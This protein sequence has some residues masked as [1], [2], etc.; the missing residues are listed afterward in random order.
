[1]VS[2]EQLMTVSQVNMYI[3]NL[4]Q[5]DSLLRSLWV[6]G[7]ISNYKRHSS[8]HLYF[9]L[10]DATGTI[11][12][13]MFRSN[14]SRLRF[15]PEHGMEVIAMGYVS[16]FER[17]GAYQLYV[18]DM[19]AA[20]AGALH[21]A[22]EKLKSKLEAEG[23]F[24]QSRKRPLPSLPQTVGIVTS[25]TGAAIRDMVSVIHRRNPQIAIRIIPAVVQGPEGVASICRALDEMYRQP[26]EVIL[27]GRGGGSLEE[28]WCFNEEAVVRKIAAS[29]VPIISAVGHETDFTLAD[30]AAD[31]RAATPSMAAELAAPEWRQLEARLEQQRLLLCRRYE[32][33]LERKKQRLALLAQ[34]PLLAE[35]ARFL[36]NWRLL[37]DKQNDAL[38]ELMER[39]LRDRENQLALAAGRLEALSPLKVLSR[40]YAVCAD[41]RGKV[42]RRAQEAEAGETVI[43]TL[44]QGRLHCV[45][46]DKEV[47]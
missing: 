31:R 2:N 38:S 10:K 5:G 18:E 16:V 34:H 8:G 7:E 11:K 29:P 20:G 4:L 3:K 41:S 21:I 37:V 6:K 28:L 23:L 40:G 43:V 47:E 1:M 27:V 25:P 42:L 36:D 46:E 17:D 13:V 24:D 32:Q 22:Y 45:V 33:L 9:S 44:E 15:E 30:F 35:P 26:V 19:L 14:A 39:L 12:C